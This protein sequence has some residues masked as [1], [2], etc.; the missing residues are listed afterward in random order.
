MM[1]FSI[2]LMKATADFLMTEPIYYIVGVIV[3]C[4]V[5]KAFTMIIKQ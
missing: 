3:F 5:A 2:K 1:E 4:F